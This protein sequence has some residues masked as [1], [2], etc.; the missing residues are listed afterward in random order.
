MPSE[1]D[2]LED[3]RIPV[4]KRSCKW[5][6]QVLCLGK[7]P[8]TIF[9]GRRASGLSEPRQG[10]SASPSSPRRREHSAR[11]QTVVSREPAQLRQSARVSARLT[12]DEPPSS[13]RGEQATGTLTAAA[14]PI[15]DT[16]PPK[17]TRRTPPVRAASRSVPSRP[18]PP[19]VQTSRG[20]GCL[21]KTG[22]GPWAFLRLLRR[23]RMAGVGKG[24]ICGRPRRLW[25]EG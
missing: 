6:V 1:A 12:K 21:K 14:G 9:P 24:P 22:T 15:P 25:R 5:V 7:D 3:M 17:R 20:K 18:P 8:S 10:A 16:A 19:G 23:H 11:G 4:E 13:G 2:A